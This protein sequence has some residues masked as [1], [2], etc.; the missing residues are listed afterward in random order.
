M[1][2]DTQSFARRI[3]RLEDIEAIRSLKNVYHLYINDCR[4]D[5]IGGLFTEDAIVDMGYMHP[6]DEPCR[7]RDNIARWYATL[8]GA[9]GLTQLKQFTHNHTVEVDAGGE[10]AS[11]WSLLEA[12]YGQG[13][14]SYNV[15]AKYEED[16]RKVG[17]RWLFDAMRLKVYFTVPMELGWATEHR[18]HLVLRPSFVLPPPGIAPS[19]PI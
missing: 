17:Q 16:Y 4:F 8:T 19:G 12:R 6:S 10:T 15:A 1:Q 11:G 13:T 3:Q 5:E 14:E 18:H 9:V 2:D 7:G